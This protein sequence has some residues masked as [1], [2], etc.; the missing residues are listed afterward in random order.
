MVI[1]SKFMDLI[2]QLLCNPA[3]NVTMASQEG[4]IPNEHEEGTAN[5][6][7]LGLPNLSWDHGY[8][9]GVWI[10]DWLASMSLYTSRAFCGKQMCGS[11]NKQYDSYTKALLSRDTYHRWRM[12]HVRSLHSD[13]SYLLING[14]FCAQIIILV[15]RSWWELPVSDL[16]RWLYRTSQCH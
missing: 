4:T 6:E 2:D 12:L 7:S 9:W 11:E 16:L 5:S 10:E 1:Y 14:S 15:C 3:I 8:S 13:P